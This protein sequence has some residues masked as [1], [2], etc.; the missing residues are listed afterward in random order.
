MTIELKR[1]ILLISLS[2]AQTIITKT[3]DHAKQANFKALGVVVLDTRG[4]VIAAAIQDGSSLVRFDVA[5]GKANGAISFNMGSRGLE[6]LA[7]DRPHFM[8]GALGVVDGIIP[9]PGGVLIKSVEGQ[10]LGAVGVSGDTSDNDELAAIAG[11]QAAG[12]VADGG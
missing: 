3:L 2:L 9:V 1:R 10:I 12:L 11:I 4:T 8:A 6:K 5:K 7:K